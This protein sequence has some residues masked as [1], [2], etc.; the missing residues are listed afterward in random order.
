[1]KNI[2]SS[3]N[4]TELFL[5]IL[6]YIIIAR[7]KE[8]KT[9]QVR[10]IRVNEV[11]ID[12]SKNQKSNQQ[13]I[14]QCHSCDTWVQMRWLCRS[15]KLR[16]FDSEDIPWN[17]LELNIF[18]LNSLEKPFNIKY[19]YCWMYSSKINGRRLIHIKIIK[20]WI[21]IDML[22]NVLFKSK[23]EEKT[24]LKRSLMTCIFIFEIFNDHRN[25][26]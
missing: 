12:E 17:W 7:M 22:W 5:W 13:R 6:R 2:F 9:N 23:F 11:S 10:S 1:M 16:Q 24:N 4:I 25:S 20:R 18:H 26:L 3:K 15:S 14:L 21:L 8:R 19:S